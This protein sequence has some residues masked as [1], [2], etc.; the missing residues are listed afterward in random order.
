MLGVHEKLVAWGLNNK[1]ILY[2]NI[3]HLNI[4]SMHAIGGW[5][6]MFLH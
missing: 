5:V 1:A 3:L 6:A 4:F 2:V